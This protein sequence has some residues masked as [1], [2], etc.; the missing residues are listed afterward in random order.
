MAQNE[1]RNLAKRTVTSIV[2]ILRCI[3]HIKEEIIPCENADFI[4]V[5]NTISGNGD[6]CMCENSLETVLS[7]QSCCMLPDD[8]K[9]SWTRSARLYTC[10]HSLI[11][12][13]QSGNQ[14]SHVH[15]L[16]IQILHS[17]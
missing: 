17:K 3:S 15:S 7:F 1:G 14:R 10:K 2:H 4:N 6:N 8:V 5:K 16:K 9:L 13:E 11:C 12:L